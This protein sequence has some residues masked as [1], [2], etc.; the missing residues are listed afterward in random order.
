MCI[1]REMRKT[2]MSNYRMNVF[3]LQEKMMGP[4]SEIKVTEQNIKKILEL[5][6]SVSR[7]IQVLIYKK[8]RCFLKH[9]HQNENNTIY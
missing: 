5:E 2:S 8:T 7:T 3:R 6:N 9:K 4:N 1:L